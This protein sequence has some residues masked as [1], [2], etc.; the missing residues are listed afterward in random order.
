[1]GERSLSYRDAL[2]EAMRLEIGNDP[3][4]VVMRED[5]SGRPR[6]MTRRISSRGGRPMGMPMEFVA[7]VWARMRARYAHQLSRPLSV[8]TTERPPPV[9]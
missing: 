1:M 8:P 6:A 7:R 3:S 2:N 9:V 5:I 4:V